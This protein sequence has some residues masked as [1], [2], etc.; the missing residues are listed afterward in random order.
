M[1]TII[2]SKYVHIIQLGLSLSYRQGTQIYAM[3]SK[4]YYGGNSHGWN[5]PYAHR[6]NKQIIIDWQVNMKLEFESQ[7]NSVSIG[8]CITYVH[9]FMYVLKL[10]VYAIDMIRYICMYVYRLVAISNITF[11][12]FN[13]RAIETLICI[14]TLVVSYV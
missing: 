1:T 9:F 14:V 12:N 11:G 7:L 13:R 2:V 8:C 5:C 6:V 4:I 10:V 3:L